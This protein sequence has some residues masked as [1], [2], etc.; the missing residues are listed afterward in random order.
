MDRDVLGAAL[1]RFSAASVF[2]LQRLQQGEGTHQKQPSGAFRRSA[3]AA[4]APYHGC[5]RALSVPSVEDA[6]VPVVFYV[7]D[8]KQLMRL[9]MQKCPSVAESIRCNA[10]A[11]L[12]AIIAHDECTAGNILNPMQRQKT[13]LFYCA[14]TLFDAILESS[15][16]W[17]PVASVTHDQ[18]LAADGGISAITAAFIR[19]WVQADLKTP[20]QVEANLRISIDL[21]MFLSDLESQRASLAAK[22]S[23]GLRPCIFCSNCLMKN[24]V[25]A[26]RHPNFHTIL[27]HNFDL[28]Q[29]FDKADLEN[30]MVHWL[31]CAP[32]MKKNEKDLRE[33]CLG[34]RLDPASLW[35]C[36]I[37]RSHFHID[38]IC[39]DSMHCYFSN[40]IVNAEIILLLQKAEEELNVT[41]DSLCRQM[42]AEGWRRRGA[43]SAHWCQ[44][45]WAAPLFGEVYKGSA[46]QTVA[47][48]LLLQWFALQWLNIANLSQHCRCFLQLG[49][50]VDVLRRARHGQQQWNLLDVEQRRHQELFVALYPQH[51]RPKHH[52]R[53]H[54][55]AMY[56][57]HNYAVACW[58]VEA[59]HQNFKG[60]FAEMLEQFLQ[61]GPNAELYSKNLLPRLLLR[62]CQAMNDR[63]FLL[64]GYE[65]IRPFAE[66]DVR[67]TTGLQ[68]VAIAQKCRLQLQEVGEGDLLLWSEDLKKGG[69]IHF[70]LAKEEKLFVYVSILKAL[71]QGPHTCHRKFQETN[72]KHVLAWDKTCHTPA[73]SC[74]KDDVII[75]LP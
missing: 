26:E 37:A 40:G 57:R 39:N 42:K 51:T 58:G 53:L 56:R 66:D 13:L 19:D 9:L 72:E 52:C 65:L 21:D 20:F 50:C 11:P 62:T 68:H 73:W 15:R 5:F 24:A 63:P 25:G 55:P 71:E 44:R 45:L 30:L 27:E 7:A 10:G 46:A 61:S 22:G 23:A 2:H 41:R 64:A 54:L 48:F 49:R 36:P 74:T 28:F 60:T 32:R 43:E 69:R 17:Y 70:F 47:L 4:L 29:Q 38:M 59:A 34:F 1:A 75:C 67:A 8:M 35:A 18:I 12:R 6:S 33:K 14:F 31:S 16:A 3:K